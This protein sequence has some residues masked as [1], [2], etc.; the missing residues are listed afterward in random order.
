MIENIKLS[1]RIHILEEQILERQKHITY[2]ESNKVG[3]QDKVK[4]YESRLNQLTELREHLY[5]QFETLRENI[6][7][8]RTLMDTLEATNIDL[9]EELT[10]LRTEHQDTQVQLANVL[11]VE[12]KTIRILIAETI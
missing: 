8:L 1:S 3:M 4:E 11:A 7:V 5:D 9:R 2:L 12:S 6:L 10:S